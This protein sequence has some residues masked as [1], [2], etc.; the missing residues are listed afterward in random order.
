LNEMIP[1]VVSNPVVGCARCRGYFCLNMLIGENR[2]KSYHQDD[3]FKEC[4]LK[5]QDVSLEEAVLTIFC[6]LKMTIV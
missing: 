4:E 2:E 6:M 1:L 3:K 5:Q